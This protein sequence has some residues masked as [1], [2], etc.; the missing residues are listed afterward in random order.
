MFTGTGR[1]AQFLYANDKRH[2][3]KDLNSVNA[4]KKKNLYKNKKA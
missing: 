2:K 1:A 4:L 3:L